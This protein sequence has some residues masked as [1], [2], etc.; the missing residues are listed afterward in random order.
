[1]AAEPTT[2]TAEPEVITKKAAEE[3]EPE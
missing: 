3:E 2:E 1:V